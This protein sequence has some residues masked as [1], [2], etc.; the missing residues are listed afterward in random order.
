M[1]L[2]VYNM[3]IFLSTIVPPDVVIMELENIS[4][5]SPN[6]TCNELDSMEFDVCFVSYNNVQL[7]VYL[8]T[9]HVLNHYE[10]HGYREFCLQ[11]GLYLH[12]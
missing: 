7:Y 1:Q 3:Y 11:Y 10:S 2:S 8:R 6:N 5:P 12:Q 4:N 9:F